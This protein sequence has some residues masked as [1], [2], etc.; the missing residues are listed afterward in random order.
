MQLSAGLLLFL[1]KVFWLVVRKIVSIGLCALLVYHTLAYVL[2]CMGAWWQA[3]H[4]LSAKLSVYRTVDSLVEF[5]IP[6]T[7]TFDASGLPV[8][9]EDGFSYRGSY[10]AVVS[11]ETRADKLFITGMESKNRSFWSDDLLAFLENHIT[12]ATES[13]QKA[14]QFLKFLLKEYPPAPRV[15][16]SFRPPHWRESVG[17][18]D[19]LLVVAARALPVHSPP[20]QS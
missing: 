19:L 7:D 15:V 9:T 2:V 18:P 20:P 12:G 3:E 5:E 6:L 11:I 16:F 1:R 8:I 17:I 14:N 4:D 13:H 10:Y